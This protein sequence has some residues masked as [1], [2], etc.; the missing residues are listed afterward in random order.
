MA[1]EEPREP[2]REQTLWALAA[3]ILFLIAMGL[4]GYALAAGAFLPFAIGWVVLQGFGYAGA[5]R[6]AHG[7]LAH[8]LFKSQ[9]MLHVLALALLF[10][11]VVRG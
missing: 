6:F 2:T 5:L 4:L 9:V 8:P 11:L 7:D 10:A 3:A 1:G